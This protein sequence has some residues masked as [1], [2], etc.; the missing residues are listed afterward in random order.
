MQHSD[1]PVL[2]IVGENGS[3]DGTRALLEAAIP[4]GLVRVVDT[5]FMA[6]GLPRLQRMAL[7]REFLAQHVPASARA[8][9]VIDLDEPYLAHLDPD[10]LSRC[11]NRLERDSS[12]FAVSATSRP[13]YYDLLAFADDGR[14]FSGLDEQ[15][16]RLTRN[17]AAY[18]RLFRDVIYPAQEHL[19]SDAD[20]PCTSAF[21]GLSLYLADTYRR[22]S[23]LP[24]NGQPWECEHVTFHRSL[25]SAS[26]RHMVID[27]NLILP[28]PPEHGRRSLGGFMWQRV[29]K[30]PKK[31]RARYSR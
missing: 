9:G 25:A 30:L 27:G 6:H 2:A 22:G 24:R 4:S 11:I 19:T 18:Y 3:R 20:I 13:T 15:I 7:G 8:V 23:Y 16:E 1:M 26:G 10:Q 21:N 31:V 17:P 5:S 28:M 29:N 14:S 12:L